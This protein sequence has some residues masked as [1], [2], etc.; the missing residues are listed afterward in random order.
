MFCSQYFTESTFYLYNETY[1]SLLYPWSHSQALYFVLLLLFQNFCLYYLQHGYAPQD[2]RSCSQMQ[3]A[4]LQGPLIVFGEIF[5]SWPFVLLED[6]RV[7]KYQLHRFLSWPWCNWH[8]WD[9]GLKIKRISYQ[10][11]LFRLAL[12]KQFTVDFNAFK[13]LLEMVLS[14]GFACFKM[15]MT[16]NLRNQVHSF[17]LLVYPSSMKQYPYWII[18]IH[19]QMDLYT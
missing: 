1:L 14:L 7:Y 17:C 13:T 4:R 2:L 18:I 15:F 3:A 19:C 9:S 16:M 8:C 5:A 12:I 6:P 10:V 11:Y